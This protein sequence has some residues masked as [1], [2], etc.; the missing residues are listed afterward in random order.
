MKF[1]ACSPLP[2]K[3]LK[4]FYSHHQDLVSTNFNPNLT[5]WFNKYVDKTNVSSWNSVIA[6]LARSGNSLEALRA[7]SFMR[8]LS[9]RPNRSTFPCTIKSCSALFDLRS[10]KQAHQQALAFGFESDLFVSSALID[11]YSKCCELT[12]AR[13]LFDG[14]CQRNVVSWTSMIV[15]YVQ[16]DD[17]HQ[18]LLLFKE[19]LSEES[20]N[21]DD[22]NV[23]MDSVV[24]I[25][26][27]S[28]CSR[29]SERE[30]TESVHGFV[31]KR[32]F[33]GD[34]GVGNTLMDAYAKCGELT[35]SRKVFDGMAQKDVVSWN[36][37]I[38]VYA[39]NGLS[40]EALE[41]FHLMV[42]NLDVCYNAVTLSA[43]LLACAHS[44][45]L[46]VGKCIHDQVL[47]FPFL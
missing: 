23:S 13:I 16:N 25:S 19:F 30:V 36:S 12:D 40:T 20:E 32:G 9:L 2:I 11:M 39:Q 33:N 15:G 4:K 35:C 5:T 22:G 10:G 47:K 6:D 1:P 31:L 8:R 27:L 17:A 18:A 26:A 34:L 43:L 44:G 46:Q 41:L 3:I 14:I 37:M 42:K 21:G 7:F 29:L 28:A 38:A 24:M 45:T